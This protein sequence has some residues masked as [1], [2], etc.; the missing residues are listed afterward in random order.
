MKITR[1]EVDHYMGTR[2]IVIEPGNRHALLIG[3]MNE[4]GKSSLIGA[5]GACLSGRESAEDPIHTGKKRASIIM[6]TEDP[7]W[8]I[9]RKFT[10]KGSTLVIKNA[11]GVAQKKPQQLLNEVIGT[12]C[13]D[14]LAF[15]KL[16]KREQ[17]DVLVGL[18]DLGIDLFEHDRERK[19]IYD[20]R[21]ATRA[22]VSPAWV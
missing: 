21:A 12:R 3:G 7:D 19:Q 20:T 11:D 15:M 22:G 2:H 10:S 5:I 1:L 18:V 13:L 9:V 4:E 17:R 16:K 6:D 14:P 8:E